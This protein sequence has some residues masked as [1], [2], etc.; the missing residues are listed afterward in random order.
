MSQTE[1]V[2]HSDRFSPWLKKWQH[3]VNVMAEACHAPAAFIVQCTSSGLM[4]VVACEKQQIKYGTGD[5]YSYDINLYCKKVIETKDPLYV[6]DASKDPFWDDNP[7]AADGMVSYL[8]MPIFMPDGDLFG[9]VCVMDIAPTNYDPVYPKL[10]EQFK[11]IVEGDLAL[12]QRNKE[13]EEIAMSDELTGLYNRRGFRILA[14][15]QHKLACRIGCNLGLLYLDIDDLK[16]INDLLGHEAGDEAI[17]AL[18]RG[19]EACLRDND[20]S[21]RIGGDEFVALVLLTEIDT[22]PAVIQRMNRFLSDQVL[23]CG[24]PL[25]VSIGGILVPEVDMDFDQLVESADQEM[26]RTKRARKAG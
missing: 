1:W 25:K 10:V 24:R 8:G 3:T 21:A 2:L 26:Y 12:I 5:V 20:I 13:L 19:M 9:T 11:D 15:Q 16:E 23:P 22:L 6:R 4:A 18:A 17:I 14:H 7:E